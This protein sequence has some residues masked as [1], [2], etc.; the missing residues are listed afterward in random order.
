MLIWH[1]NIPEEKIDFAERIQGSLGA[2]DA[3]QRRAQLG[4]PVRLAAAAAEQTQ[5]NGDAPPLG[6]PEV[7]GVAA[8]VGLTCWL[9]L[10][11]FA[12]ASPVPLLD[13][14]LEE[15]LTYTQ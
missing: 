9:Q 12:L 15:S 3:R 10:R 13:P 1:L 2:D 6:V 7:A 11:T 8:G 4:G 5:R 14:L